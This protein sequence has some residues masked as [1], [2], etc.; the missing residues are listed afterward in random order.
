MNILN[1]QQTALALPYDRLVPALAQAVLELDA[2]T[3]TA[4]DRLVL[5][6]NASSVLLNMPA[7]AADIGVTK[8]I[9]VHAD[10]ARNNLPA[11]QGEVIAFDAT[12][13]RRLAL[14]DGPTVTARRTAA[15]TLLGMQ[16]LLP[17]AAQTAL[18]IGTGFQ[19]AVHAQALVEFFGITTL[20]IAG[21]TVDK[22]RAFG[23]EVTRLFPG[24]QCHAIAA[25]ELL[26]QPAALPSTDVV[27]ALTTSRTPV[28]PAHLPASTLAVGVGAFKPDMA[29]I[30]PEILHSRTII[31][32]DVAGAHHEAGD[33]IQAKVDWSGVMG[34]SEILSGRQA[35]PTPGQMPVFKT[36]GQ[37]AWDLA[38]ARVACGAL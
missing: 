27:I 36:V 18:L 8:V 26:H 2:G 35:K 32:D 13:G 4:P 3:I 6:I 28:M 12:T 9:T 22:A 14:L 38:A 11:I 17:A 15:M 29:E 10:N 33:L 34:L 7:I 30:P 21:T 37:A 1:A 19:A 31:V 23:A 20:Y 5:P 24:T 16:T 25:H